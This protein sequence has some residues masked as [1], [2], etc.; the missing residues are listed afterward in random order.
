M[1]SKKSGSAQ[2]E[3]KNRR[4]VILFASQLP[5]DR[6]PKLLLA[7]KFK[8]SNSRRPEWDCANPPFGVKNNKIIVCSFI[9]AQD[10]TRQDLGRPSNTKTDEFLK[11]N[12]LLFSSYF[13]ISVVCH[14]CTLSTCCLNHLVSC[15]RKESLGRKYFAKNYKFKNSILNSIVIQEQNVKS[16]DKLLLV[17]LELSSKT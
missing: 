17:Y 15:L 10:F 5:Y 13:F 1:F 12:I 8:I 11:T 14:I 9:T 3:A 7:Q 6:K 4:E 16:T 2:E